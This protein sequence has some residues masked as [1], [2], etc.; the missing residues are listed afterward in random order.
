MN[1]MREHLPDTLIPCD[2]VT[3]VE[4]TMLSYL[5]R[6]VLLALFTCWAIS[7]LAFVIIQLPPGD[8]VDAYIAQSFRLGQRHLG[9]SGAAVARRV[10][11]RSSRC[12]SSTCAGCA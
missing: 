2:P 6:R 1:G 9:R 11:A 7:V 5:I 4:A 8:F 10:R 12:M 3:P